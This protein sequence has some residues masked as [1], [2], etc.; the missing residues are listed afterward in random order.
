MVAACFLSLEVTYVLIKLMAIDKTVVA[1]DSLQHWSR[2]FDYNC[3]CKDDWLVAQT[4]SKCEVQNILQ[5][6]YIYKVWKAVTLAGKDIDLCT[7]VADSW[8][9]KAWQ[10]STDLSRNE[11]W[12]AQHGFD[13]MC[14]ERMIA[15]IIESKEQYG[16]LRRWRAAGGWVELSDQYNKLIIARYAKSIRHQKTLA[17]REP[18]TVHVIHILHVWVYKKSIG[19]HQAPWEAHEMRHQ[20]SS[21]Q[22]IDRDKS[23]DNILP[24]T[25]MMT[26]ATLE[27]HIGKA[28]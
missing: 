27:R 16:G 9:V 18:K 6:A 2:D 17:A 21:C 14:L 5:R 8:L 25:I 3:H 12:K 19:R 23:I 13:L 4:C 24:H 26:A 15:F 20:S 11:L 10:T 28:L 1:Y 22:E 7:A